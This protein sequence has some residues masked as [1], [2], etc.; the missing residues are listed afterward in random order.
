MKQIKIVIERS[1]DLFSSYAENVEG[2]YGG[3]ETVEAA[4]QSIVDAIG[5]FKKNNSKKNIPDNLNGDYELIYKYDVQSFLDY[6]KGIFTPAALERIAGIN[7]KQIQHYSTGHRKPRL[8][9]RRKI[10]QALHKLGQELLAV[11]L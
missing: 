3:G 8:A 9:Q 11:E 7:Q 10:E 4:K 1:A 2:I 6:Y 5:L